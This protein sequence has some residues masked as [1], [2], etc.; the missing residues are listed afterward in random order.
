MIEWATDVIDAIGYLGIA[1]LIALESIVPPIPSELVLLLTG[2]NASEGRFSYPLAV[3]AATV[4]SLVGAFVLYAVGRWVGEERMERLVTWATK[5]LGF[6]R[7]DIDRAFDWFERH[8]DMAVLIC[9][10][11]PLI[12]SVVSIPA[13]GSGMPIR[14]FVLFTVLG[15]AVWNAVW[16]GI[17]WALGDQWEKAGEWGDYLQYAVLAAVVVGGIVLVIRQRRK[18]R[19]EAV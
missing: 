10:C 6:K 11:V 15:S 2:F 13:G 7:A 16:I 17:G 3:A 19:S 14:R 18:A 5:W 4:G 1:F 9:R 8:E 12:R